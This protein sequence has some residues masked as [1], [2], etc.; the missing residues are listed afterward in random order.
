MFLRGCWVG[1][2]FALP[3]L[4]IHFV[5]LFHHLTLLHITKHHSP[6]L[7]IV[8]LS[9]T[10]T[11]SPPK[12]LRQEIIISGLPLVVPVNKFQQISS[13]ETVVTSQDALKRDTH[14]F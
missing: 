8:K 1:S 13:V 5:I 10:K 9:P 12:V 7:I 11:Y 2:L 4:P 14:A 6:L 3:L